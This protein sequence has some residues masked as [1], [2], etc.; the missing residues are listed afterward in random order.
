MPIYL[1]MP[2]LDPA[3]PYKFLKNAGNILTTPHWH[4]EYELLWLTAG[5]ANLGINDQQFHLHAGE[6]AFFNSGDIHYVVATP[7]SQRYVYQFDLSFF[8]D[9]VAKAKRL[10]LAAMFAGMTQISSQWPPAVAAQMVSLLQ[11]L[12]EESQR[13][14]ASGS[15]PQPLPADAD[16]VAL[17]AIEGLVYELVVLMSRSVPRRAHTMTPLTK[18][19][20]QQVLTALNQVFKYVEQHYTDNV[21]LAA[22]GASVNF[23]QY[24]FARWFKRNVGKTFLEFLNDYRLDKAKWALINTDQP[25]TTILQNAGFTSDKTFYRLFKQRLDTTPKRYRAQYQLHES[26]KD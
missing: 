18:I 11:M 14:D 9:V 13:I 20:S 25:V 17:L 26:T 24:Y 7:N 21:T 3:F 6:V 23:S 16:P 19:K 5:E 22:A 1:E 2:H 15:W 10:D 8:N 4:K 12:A